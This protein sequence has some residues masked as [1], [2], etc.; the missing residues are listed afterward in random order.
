MARA[1]EVTNG[2]R[3]Q[4]PRD[5]VAGIVALVNFLNQFLDDVQQVSKPKHINSLEVLVGLVTG[6]LGDSRDF[7]SVQFD[8]A[9]GSESEAVAFSETFVVDDPKAVGALALE[10]DDV[11]AVD[12][13]CSL[14]I[15][16]LW[17][18]AC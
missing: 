5:L 4:I 17:E 18:D 6:D 15:A 12:R 8:A 14:E 7:G 16:G 3:E 11:K 1:E 2:D 9:T 13:H 10:K